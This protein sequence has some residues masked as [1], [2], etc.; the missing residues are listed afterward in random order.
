MKF[1]IMTHW[2]TK[3][4]VLFCVSVFMS[5]TL[6]SQS[7]AS[8]RASLRVGC[9]DIFKDQHTLYLRQIKG[10]KV[11]V[12]EIQLNIHS[13]NEPFL[14]QGGSKLLFFRTSEDAENVEGEAK[15]SAI[16]RLPV[17]GSFFL[18]FVPRAN[19]TETAVLD[20]RVLAIPSDNVA[21]GSFMLMN[22]SPYPLHAS[23]GKTR[24]K[25]LPGKRKNFQFPKG[26]RNARTRM[27]IEPA[28]GK[29]QSVRSSHWSL[30]PDTR[31][32]VILYNAP[33][34]KGV[35]FK[36]IVDRKVKKKQANKNL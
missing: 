33:E 10:K 25:I 29:F 13:M 11:E 28:K 30:A 14:Y 34:S 20:Y 8:K 27:F 3:L 32:F 35:M 16:C 22:Y 15:P 12:K 4:T 9:T 31:E 7:S 17:G 1:K 19:S 18:L 21:F 2:L 24:G 36:H 26:V 23:I 5:G 6:M